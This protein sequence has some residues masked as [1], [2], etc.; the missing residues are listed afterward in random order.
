MY[1]LQKICFSRD[2]ILIS[3]VLIFKRDID[4]KRGPT[5]RGCALNDAG[6]IFL[7]SRRSMLRKKLRRRIFGAGIRSK[8]IPLLYLSGR[9]LWLH[10]TPLIMLNGNTHGGLL[11][12]AF[13]TLHV[14]IKSHPFKSP[15]C[16][17]KRHKKLL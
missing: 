10:I 16:S 9:P 6:E 14:Q 3:S 17:L 11:V 2:D 13:Y 7:S 8:G 12:A 4:F 5:K 1:S 15:L